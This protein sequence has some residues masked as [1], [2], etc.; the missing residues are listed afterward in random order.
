MPGFQIAQ[1]LGLLLATASPS[2]VATSAVAVSPVV[3]IPMVS[4]TPNPTASQLWNPIRQEITQDLALL[5]LKAWFFNNLTGLV[6]STIYVFFFLFLWLILSR[7]MTLLF[8]R[9]N[10]DETAANFVQEILKYTL[11]CIGGLASLG[12]LGINTTSILASLGVVG[13]TLG[14]AAKDTLSNVIAGIF[15]FWDRPFTTGDL[16]EIE[17]IYGTVQRITLRST[18]IVTVDGKMVAIPNTSIVNNKVVSYTNFPHLRLDIDVTIGVEENIEAAR[19]LLLTTLQDEGRYMT[20]PA[21]TVVVTALNDYNI[22]LQVRAWIDDER[23]HVSERFYLREK[24]FVVLR[25]SGVDLPY[26]T[27]QMI[28]PPGY[29]PRPEGK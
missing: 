21:P 28:A 4:Q 12:A 8:R 20:I 1:D 24:I 18:R 2:A 25:D 11:F 23:Q 19:E 14:F 27:I 13:L 17:G 15:I 16:V 6:M 22:A 29:E 26:E 10:L 9:I 3:P 7:S 5:N